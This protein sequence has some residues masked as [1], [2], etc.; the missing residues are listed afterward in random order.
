[1]SAR[2]Y[3]SGSIRDI[4]NVR[5]IQNHL[6]E[7]GCSITHDWTR[8]SG[9]KMTFEEA[10]RQLR[11]VWAAEVLILVVHPRLKAG[12]MEF[13]AAVGHRVP[14]IVVPHADVSESMWYTLPWVRMA[15][16]DGDLAEDV[17]EV[18]GW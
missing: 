9:P 16:P 17:F 12:W 7:R 4:E 11:A 10:D 18:V 13:G 8:F 14:C 6:I 1:M 15:T 3:V 5:N 2:V